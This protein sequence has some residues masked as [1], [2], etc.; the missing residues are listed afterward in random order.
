MISLKI[1]SR[2]PDIGTTNPVESI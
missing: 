2:Q 1:N